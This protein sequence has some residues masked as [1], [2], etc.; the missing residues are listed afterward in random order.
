MDIPI[1]ALLIFVL[2]FGGLIAAL[3]FAY[4]K[5]Q[6]R[7]AAYV[8]LAERRG[9]SY[10]IRTSMSRPAEV[11]FADK[12][13]DLTITV[14]RRKARKTSKGQSIQG[15]TTELRMGDPRLQGALILYAPAMPKKFDGVANAL[16]GAFDNKVAKFL[17]GK[18]FGDEIGAYMGQMTEQPSPDGIAL[19]IL[20]NV[21]PDPMFDPAAAHRALETAPKGGGA[22]R[23]TMILVT[24][25]G[26]RIRMG[27]DLLEAEEIEKLL[28][29]GLM[30]RSELQR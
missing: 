23:S 28:D 19:T 30:L 5:E 29:A 13:S 11:H 6:A 8:A 27:R 16:M 1:P 20:G 17:I 7:R 9:L 3:V 12:E 24:E 26:T 21:D 15:G 14:V 22:D 25:A 10:E 18:M 2:V 4:R